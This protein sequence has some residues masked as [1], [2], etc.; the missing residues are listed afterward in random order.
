MINAAIKGIWSLVSVL[1]VVSNFVPFLKQFTVHGKLNQHGQVPYSVSKAN[2]KW[3]YVTGFI[4]HVAAYFIFTVNN[5]T[6]GIILIHLTR[7]IYECFCIVEFGA[8]RMSI[9]GAL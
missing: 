3:F 6:M 9:A 1:A 2:F 4:V 5:S 7:R 8:S